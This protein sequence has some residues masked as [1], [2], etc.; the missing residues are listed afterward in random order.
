MKLR[1]LAFDFDGTIALDGRL[2]GAVAEA[3][4]EARRAGVRT[5]LVSSRTLDDLHALLPVREL[6]DAVVA[7]N[8]GVVQLRD[9]APPVVLGRGPDPVLVAELR[10]RG[11]HARTGSCVLEV[12]AVAAPDVVASLHSLGIPYGIA[13]ERGK[14]LVLP[15]GVGKACGLSEAV[16]RLGCSLHNTVA[17]G[18]GADDGPMLDACEIGEAVAWGSE[19]LQRTVGDVLPGTGPAA[20]ADDVRRLLAL[21]MPSPRSTRHRQPFLRLRL[22]TDANGQPVDAE[23]RGRNVVVA[24]D[25]Q[26]GKSWL[27]GMLCEQLVLKRYAVFILDP[28]GDYAC[29]GALPGV[30]LHRV[31]SHA[32]ELPGWL[33]RVFRQ[34]MLSVVLDLSALPPATKRA[35]VRSLLRTID[36]LRR[37]IGVPHRVVLDEAHYFFHSPEDAALF[38]PHLGGHCLVTYRVP[39]LAPAVLRGC[40]AIL[41]TKLADRHVAARLL[42]LANRDASSE[43]VDI[44]ATLPIGQ[45]VLLPMDPA[46]EHGITR[47]TVAPRVTDHVRHRQKYVDFGVAPGRE[48]VFTRNG[49][50]T[51][52]RARTLSDLLATLPSVPDDVVMRHFKARDFHNWFE[53]AVGDRA[54]REALACAENGDAAAARA[55]IARAIRDRYLEPQSA[56]INGARRGTRESAAPPID[57]TTRVTRKDG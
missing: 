20:V 5:V 35:A 16:W 38:H 41:V 51:G 44:L 7:E 18:G 19:A 53:H 46:D 6:F 23:D 10:R 2:D 26:T 36:A 21:D 55:A 11:V 28:E 47:F 13:F 12:D 54:L 39:D 57:G 31:R 30:I 43:W 37:T 50:A 49:C 29:L 22:G 15:P 3:L 9:P 27:V 24:G 14:L 52:H 33:E 17:I 25:P 56:P 34:P 8:G 45:A 40:D 32:D 42:R 4:R 1:V 48:F